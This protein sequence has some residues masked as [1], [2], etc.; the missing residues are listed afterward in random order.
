MERKELLLNSRDKL[1]V[2]GI[3]L[4][5]LVLFFVNPRA[6]RVKIS[7][8]NYNNIKDYVVVS[9]KTGEVIRSTDYT[10]F[11]LTNG[12]DSIKV[13]AFKNLDLE[14][15]QNIEVTGEVKLYERKLEVVLD[16]FNGM[17]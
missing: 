16:K 10:L 4:L 5:L 2:S 13:V 6:N 1:L 7:E 17:D 11:N 3:G 12:E 8:L 14:E 15:G 9:G